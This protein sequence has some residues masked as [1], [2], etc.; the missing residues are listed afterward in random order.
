MYFKLS[1]SIY[2]RVPSGIFKYNSFIRTR[3]NGKK[4]K[5]GV[6]LRPSAEEEEAIKTFEQ[7]FLDK[8]RFASVK[9]KKT[10]DVQSPDL[11]T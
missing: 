8:F 3:E 5:V 6:Y 10:N 2:F 9:D 11:E 1:I 7:S 4:W